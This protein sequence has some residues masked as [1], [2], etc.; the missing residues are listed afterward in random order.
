LDWEESKRKGSDA[1]K[2]T[3]IFFTYIA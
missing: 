2:T 1:R 3:L